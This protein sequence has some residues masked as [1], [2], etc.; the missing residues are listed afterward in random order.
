MNMVNN[1][2]LS[3]QEYDNLKQ[4]PITLAS[5]KISGVKSIAPHFMEYVRKY[6]EIYF[7]RTMV[8]IFIEMG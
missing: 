6:L 1:N 3:A 7:L 2:M 5:E 4:Q 8:M